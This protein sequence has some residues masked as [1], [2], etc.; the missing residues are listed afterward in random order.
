ML[1]SGL[2]II[3]SDLFWSAVSAARL[4][5]QL[6]EVLR[7]WGKQKIY[8]T[9]RL[10]VNL[11]IMVAFLWQ[12]ERSWL[13]FSLQPADPFV[14]TAA[15][16]AVSHLL[17]ILVTYFFPSEAFATICPFCILPPVCLSPVLQF[18]DPSVYLITLSDMPAAPSSFV[19]SENSVIRLHHPHQWLAYNMVLS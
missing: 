8:F 7:C 14:R 17:L 5:T 10:L 11:C 9:C 4:V 15:G 18:P 12:Q 1:S 2:F 16:P 13:M 6:M 3:D 19:H